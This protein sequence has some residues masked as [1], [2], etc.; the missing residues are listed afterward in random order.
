MTASLN[1]RKHDKNMTNNLKNTL[2]LQLIS[3]FIG[4]ALF[5]AVVTGSG[6]MGESLAAGNA[7]VALLGNSI[8]T[9]CGLYVLISLL[10]PISGAH[11]NPVVSLMFWRIGV[12]DVRALYVYLC[13]QFS[14]AIAGVWLTHLMFGLPILQQ[15][16]NARNGVGIWASELVSTLVLLGVIYLGVQYAKDK[17]AM[18]VALTVTGGYWFTS[19]TFFA[20]PAVTIARSLT[21]T[22]VGISP[23]DIAGF[24]AAQSLGILFILF[25]TRKS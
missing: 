4:T 20:N 5:L 21:N 2:K 15:A 7:A 6:I 11:F 18:L 16:D 8:A 14:G 1:Q 10:G 22:F 12:L 23:L 19:S 25:L 24:I 3:E 13:A 9:G 17:I